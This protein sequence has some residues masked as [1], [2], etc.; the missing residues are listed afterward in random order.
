[1]FMKFPQNQKLKLK[2]DYILKN[3][4]QK[5]YLEIHLIKCLKRELKNMMNIM[6]L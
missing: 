5:K 2:W 4:N 6:M 3:K 1:M